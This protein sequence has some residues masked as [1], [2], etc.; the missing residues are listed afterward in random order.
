MT[1]LNDAFVGAK[2]L[3]RPIGFATAVSS[4]VYVY[5]MCCN[6]HS[7]FVVDVVHDHLR[8]MIMMIMTLMMISP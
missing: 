5:Y 1:Y 8:R 7:A 4:T 3:D 2:Q 6:I